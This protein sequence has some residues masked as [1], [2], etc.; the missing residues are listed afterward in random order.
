MLRKN[1][2]IVYIV[3]LTLKNQYIFGQLTVYVPTV[4]CGALEH[5]S[6]VTDLAKLRGQST[7]QSRKTAMW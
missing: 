7:L 2:E 5:Y 6:T 1:D 3:S 4:W